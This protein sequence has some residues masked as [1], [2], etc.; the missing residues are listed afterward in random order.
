MKDSDEF[1]GRT[2]KEGERGK[3]SLREGGERGGGSIRGDEL[4]LVGLGSTIE[5]Y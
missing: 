3:E 5:K 4:S 1:G 2:E